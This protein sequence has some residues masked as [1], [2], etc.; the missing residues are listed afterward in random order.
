MIKK[1]IFL[2]LTIFPCLCF[3][4]SLRLMNDSAF[5]LTAV[6]LGA[7]GTN[8]ATVNLRPQ[9]TYQWFMN[10]D[11]FSSL[12]YQIITPY[13]VIWYCQE[14]GEF[15]VQG[16]IEQAATISAQG[17]PDGNKVCKVNKTP[18]AR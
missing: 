3:S 4:A 12:N 10:T 2:L 13:T 6:I 16:N 11:V 1:G 15:G 8:L 18:K 17:A 14:G 9:E 5:K 7:D